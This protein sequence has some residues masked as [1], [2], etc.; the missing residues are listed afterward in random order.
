MRSTITIGM[1]LAAVLAAASGSAQTGG[2]AA[3]S[4]LTYDRFMHELSVHERFTMFSKELTPEQKAGLIGT[5][6]ARCLSTMG[7]KLTPEQLTVVKDA[8]AA[9]SADAF[10]DPPVAGSADKMRAVE[11]RAR[12]VFTQELG[13]QF[14]TL[15]KECKA[16]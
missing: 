14:F 5:H 7:S 6:Y 12:A 16:E 4:S 15:E 13:V 10:R 1:A 9:L 2:A 3:D 8:Q 11:T